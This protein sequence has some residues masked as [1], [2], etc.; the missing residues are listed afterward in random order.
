[1]GRPTRKCV[2]NVIYHTYSR[3]IDL[4]HLLKPD[5]M[6]DQFLIAVKK[7]QET[8]NFHFYNFVIMN[9]H[10]HL[11][12]G[13]IEDEATISQIMQLIKSLFARAYNKLMN[14]TGPVWNERFKDKIIED[15]DDPEFYANWLTHYLGNNPVLAN[16]VKDPRDYKYS[17]FNYYV[18]PN[19]EPPV[20]MTHHK[21]FLKLGNTF[22]ERAQK[23]LG[24]E[25]LYQKT[26][27]FT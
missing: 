6:K 19:Y 10:F 22:A 3:C 5:Q 26:L 12:I 18:D 1:M 15:S 9:T 24:Y 11:A 4:G 25:F 7:A 8:Y 21:Y 27:S 17:G 23:L 20:K 2:P 16:L 13:T 14:R